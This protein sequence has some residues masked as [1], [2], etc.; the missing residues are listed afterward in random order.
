ML[1]GMNGHQT[2]DERSHHA[3]HCLY[4][5][6]LFL[7]LIQ[8]TGQDHDTP[9]PQ[10]RLAAHWGPVLLA[11]VDGGNAGVHCDLIGDTLHWAAHLASSGREQQLLVSE[12]L[13]NHIRNS[14]D[15]HWQN[16]P[17]VSDLHGGEQATHWLQQ[18]EDKHQLLISRQ[19]KHII[20][21]AES[22]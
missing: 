19:I 18:L 2:D 3:L 5:A 16:G 9:A 7:G 17:L 20:A 4:A 11:P 12:A 15:I 6:Q 13:R 1:F 14:E 21:M 10:L 22:A 8:H